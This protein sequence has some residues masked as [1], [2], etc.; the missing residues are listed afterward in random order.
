MTIRCGG[1]RIFFFFF[2]F[3][4]AKQVSVSRGKKEIN[5]LQF[6]PSFTSLSSISNDRNHFFFL[7]MK[8]TKYGRSLKILKYTLYRNLSFNLDEIIEHP[9]LANLEI[10]IEGHDNTVAKQRNVW[11]FWKNPNSP[12]NLSKIIEHWKLARP[13]HH[14]RR[15]LYPLSKFT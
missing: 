10:R 8:Q 15:E 2:L 3:R 12:F 4:Y 14:R 13:W 6:A 7:S 9:K 1:E 5:L 11:K